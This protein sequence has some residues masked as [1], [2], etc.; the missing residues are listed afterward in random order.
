VKFGL[1]DQHIIAGIGNCYS[2]ESCFEA[3]LLPLKPIPDVSDE[4]LIKLH[5][6]LRSTLKRAIAAGGY[7]ERPFTKGDTLTGG[8]NEKCFVYDRPGEPC[9][10][11][12]HAITLTHHNKRK[13]FYHPKSSQ[14]NL[15]CQA[16]LLKV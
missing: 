3:G 4:A 11:C 15:F 8:Y 7:M 16:P 12:G 6:G 1:V 5:A 14:R 9:P 13:V 2:D 10:R